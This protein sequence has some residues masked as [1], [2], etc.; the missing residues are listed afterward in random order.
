[1][2]VDSFEVEMGN[3]N[4]LWGANGVVGICLSPDSYYGD[5]EIQ[6]SYLQFT[7]CC[8]SVRLSW[9]GYL[10]CYQ[11]GWVYDTWTYSNYYDEMYQRS[12]NDLSYSTWFTEPRRQL[13]EFTNEEMQQMIANIQADIEEN[14][15]HMVDLRQQVNQAKDFG[16][17]FTKALLDRALFYKSNN[18]KATLIE[19]GYASEA[20][21]IN[22][23]PAPDSFSEVRPTIQDEEYDRFTSDFTTD[24]AEEVCASVVNAKFPQQ[25]DEER[26]LREHFAQG[27]LKAMEQEYSSALDSFAQAKEML[28]DDCDPDILALF[29]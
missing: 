1:M 4:H 3:F 20:A 26:F 22:S 15:H 2:W 12:W 17:Y 9:D 21:H 11:P 6:S 16:V 13:G 19:A 28:P 29:F 14:P 5:A 23:F 27:C 25:P 7:G 8:S 18:I 10:S 24:D